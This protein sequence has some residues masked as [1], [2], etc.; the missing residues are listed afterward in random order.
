MNENRTLILNPDG[1][2]VEQGGPFLVFWLSWVAY[3]RETWAFV[4][5]LL[6]CG[7][8]ATLI[9]LGL[10]RYVDTHTEAWL[11]VLHTAR[12]AREYTALFSNTALAHRLGRTHDWV[13]IY[14]DGAGPEHQDTIVTEARGPLEGRRVVRGREGECLAWYQ[15]SGTPGDT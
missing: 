3:V 2:V 14:H 4:A 1:R 7:I 12:G 6:L 5:R 11:P 10:D 9:S 8:V 15:E 13:V